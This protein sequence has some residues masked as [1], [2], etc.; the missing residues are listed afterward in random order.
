[1]PPQ[2]DSWGCVSKKKSFSD[3][4]MSWIRWPSFLLGSSGHHSSASLGNS[5]R[6]SHLPPGLPLL[7]A[8]GPGVDCVESFLA[9]DTWHSLCSSELSFGARKRNSIQTYTKWGNEL[10]HISKTSGWLAWATAEFRILAF[11]PCFSALPPSEWCPPWQHVAYFKLHIPK[12]EQ[13][14]P[15]VSAY[16]YSGI[17]WYTLFA[18][19]PSPNGSLCPA[20][21][22]LSCR[23]WGR[24]I[25]RCTTSG[26]L[27]SYEKT[28]LAL[29]LYLVWSV[30]KSG[31]S[32]GQK[33]FV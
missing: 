29:R 22:W 4:R 32:H 26:H 23:G 3:K 5:S 33:L 17:S 15:P 7:Q 14:S 25:P 1:M 9:S 10:T 2:S 8:E 27:P 18:S 13:L 20:R 24:D 31:I 21:G 16:Q 12:K 6:L 28:G 30:N 11:A 19:C